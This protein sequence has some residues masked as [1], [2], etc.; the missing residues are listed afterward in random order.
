[1][2]ITSSASSP[3]R[4]AKE[5]GVKLTVNADAHSP[6]G[7]DFLPWG[8]RMARRAGLEAEDVVNTYPLEKLRRTLKDGR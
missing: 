7:F 1:M 3:A 6:S 2:L 5:R 8:M 4:R